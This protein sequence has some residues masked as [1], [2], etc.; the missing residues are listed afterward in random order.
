MSK[1]IWINPIGTDE[2]DSVIRDGLIEIKQQQTQVEVVSLRKG[3]KHLEYRYYETLVIPEILQIIRKAER[4][5]YDGAVIGCF[6]DLGLYDARAIVDKMVITAP[7]EACGYLAATMG[8][9]F[10]VIVTED[11]CI[12]QMMSNFV[13]YGLKDKVASF[14]PLGM[15]VNE[16]RKDEELTMKKIKEKAKEAVEKDRAEV[17]IL[18]CTI[19]FGFYKEIQDDLKV[20]I[21]DA[22]VVPFKYAEFLIELKNKFGWLH[23]KK[24]GFR[25]PPIY[26]MKEWKLDEQFEI[27]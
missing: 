9:K 10:S 27:L 2:Y 6:Y 23:S 22:V 13:L 18:G 19:Q 25:S 16:L 14:K 26:E 1:V 21:L 7:A 8:H 17:V 20:P 24:Y 11:L 3:P 12:P 5:G 15:G 4:D